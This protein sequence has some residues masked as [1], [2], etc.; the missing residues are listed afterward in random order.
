LLSKDDLTLSSKDYLRIE[1]A[2][3]FI[4][5]N[6]RE[7]PSLKEIA[8]SVGLSEYHFQRLFRRWTG[9]SP[10]QFL[11]FLTIEHA[12]KLLEESRSLLEVTYKSGLSSLGRLHDL[13]VT[14]DAVT[15]GE[16]KKKG[17]GLSITYGI[18]PSP[19]GGCLLSVTDRG[20]CGLS[21][22]TEGN[23]EEAIKNLRDEWS[24]AIFVENPSITK[25]FVD[26]IFVPSK[27]KDKPKLNLFLRGTN[28]QI[29]VWEALL[30]IPSE[31]VLSYE[32]IADLIGKPY[33][34]Q[35]VRKAM[36]TNPIGYII[37]CHRI[38][39]KIGIIGDYKWGTA[40]KRAMLG[41]EVAQKN[42]SSY[43]EERY[44]RIVFETSKDE[45]HHD[46][47]NLIIK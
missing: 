11:K 37:P 10:K 43:Q 32:D 8:G 4:E 21:F 45:E 26:Q 9:I 17:E 36:M 14:I 24:G 22:I 7:Q 16:F 34:V 28:F 12:K 18:H 20:I 29:K 46:T 6:F 35:D 30:S 39:Y 19:F 40:R 1:Q 5:E 31:F 15:P 27:R 3:L 25:P 44:T 13:F 23:R 38:I 41:W 42:N 47:E 2:V 33:A